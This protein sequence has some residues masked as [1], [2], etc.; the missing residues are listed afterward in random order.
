MTNKQEEC[1]PH[2][3]SAVSHRPLPSGMCSVVSLS[4]RDQHF[5]GFSFCISQ[6]KRAYTGDTQHKTMEGAT[7]MEKFAAECR[8]FVRSWSLLVS[9]CNCKHKIECLLWLA[10]NTDK[11]IDREE[12]QWMLGGWSMQ[13]D[14]CTPYTH[15]N[16]SIHMNNERWLRTLVYL[17][18]RGVCCINK[19]GWQT[20]QQIGKDFFW[21]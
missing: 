11:L 20:E 10:A 2:R 4:F 13:A 12:W 7:A 3:H 1:S 21:W 16:P 14:T 6:S 9:N 19:P 8:S 17:P 5:E 18:K 15:M